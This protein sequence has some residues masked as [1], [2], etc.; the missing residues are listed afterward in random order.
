MTAA[1]MYPRPVVQD[2]QRKPIA[3]VKDLAKIVKALPA[4]AITDAGK[5][6]ILKV[7]SADPYG[8]TVRQNTFMRVMSATEV[9]RGTFVEPG[10]RSFN[11][12]QWQEAVE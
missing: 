6:T 12:P 1:E 10:E 5:E 11:K 2:F 4:E 8:S 9:S 7:A 3:M